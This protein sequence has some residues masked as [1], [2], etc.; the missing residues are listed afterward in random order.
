MKK[1]LPFL[2]VA[3]MSCVGEYDEPFH[4]DGSAGQDQNATGTGGSNNGS[5]GS[6]G[7]GGSQPGTGGA[8]VGSGGEVGSGGSS[9]SGGAPPASG[10][11]V[12]SGGA[13]GS[14]GRAAGGAVGSGG[15]A[16]GGTLGGGGR[17]GMGGAAT[18]G[19]AGRGSGGAAGGRS[20]GSAGGRSGTGSGGTGAGGST[21]TVCTS[22]KTW[23]NGNGTDMRPGNDCKGCHSFSISGTIYPTAHE[24]N[25]CYGT[26][27]GGIKVVITGADGSTVTLTPSANSGNFYSNTAIKT[28]YTAKITNSSG[29]T[30]MMT[31]SQTTGNCNSCHTPTG[32]NGAPGRIYVP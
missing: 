23:T 10:G 13:V 8:V 21:A 29:G 2:L 19:S 32:A 18:G 6:V 24:P 3:T 7:S 26:A 22:G 30:R 4:P 31:E 27:A 1:A 25:N 14:G 16:S 17:T 5:G 15:Q 28:P 20:G 12:G 11:T 9:G